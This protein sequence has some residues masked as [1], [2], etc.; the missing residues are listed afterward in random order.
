MQRP[1]NQRMDGL[2]TILKLKVS[3]SGVP[4]TRFKSWLWQSGRQPFLFSLVRLSVARMMPTHGGG[5]QDVSP[6]LNDSLFQGHPH[7]H[8]Q[9]QSSGYP[10]GQLEHTKLPHQRTDFSPLP[11]SVLLSFLTFTQF[12]MSHSLHNFFFSLPNKACGILVGSNAVGKGQPCI[13][14]SS[15]RNK[16]EEPLLM[17]G[18]F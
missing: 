15:L 12:K 17:S 1:E 6:S 2:E 5:G 11:P 3:D 13:F 18:M 7:R 4:R 9:K 14:S 16:K 8:S 10:K